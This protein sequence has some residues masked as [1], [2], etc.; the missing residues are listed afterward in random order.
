M[1]DQ[2]WDQA[3]LELAEDPG[4]ALPHVVVLHHQLVG[5]RTV[6]WYNDVPL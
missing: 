5:T 1:V 2:G 3:P 6:I 4:H